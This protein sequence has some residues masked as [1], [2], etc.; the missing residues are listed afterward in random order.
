M[1]ERLSLAV[2]GNGPAAAEAILA[3]RASGYTGSIHLF[4]DNQ[5]PPYNPMLG[6]YLV[7]GTISEDRVFPFGDERTFYRANEVL[8]HLGCPVTR[9]DAEARILVT[10]QGDEY[11]YDR[12]L[13]GT[14]A[15]PAVPPIPGLREV[16]EPGIGWP[17]ES[18]NSEP[19]AFTIQDLAGVQALKQRVD[20]LTARF[21][22]HENKRAVDSAPQTRMAGSRE[23]ASKR[24]RES[25]PRAAVLGA[26]FAG[27]K[28]A[29]VLHQCG[30]RVSLIEREPRLLPLAA[31]P[32]CA[33]LLEEHLAREGYEL[34][35]G[36]ALSRVT[37]ESSAE[38]EHPALRLDFGALPGAAD[39]TGVGGTA[40]EE[41]AAQETVD[42]L[43]VCAGTRPALSFL[44]PGQVAVG[45]GILVDEKMRSSLPTLYAAGDAAQGRN[46]L[47]GRQEIIGLWSSARYQ[48][49]AAGRSLAG[50]PLPYRGG[51]PHNIT[52]VGK[53]LFAAVG[54]IDDYDDMDIIS[55]DGTHEF[56]VWREGRLV[57][58]NLLGR[59]LHAGVIRQALQRAG[60]GAIADREATWISFSG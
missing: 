26:S 50:C 29:G 21:A 42:L 38:N 10:G 60:T 27:V 48:G 43:V 19:L 51:V 34:R 45:T 52:H 39:P 28:I 13:V 12:C 18:H 23:V 32:Q 53:L 35:L 58:V 49:Q 25:S 59:C 37:R 46:L 8:A 4:A 3:L 16:L 44:V 7:A 47:S 2:I 5:H 54:C 15:R 17:G 11:L 30:F 57:G 31:L 1:R 36:A 24:T 40:C 33:R 6:P 14:G 55:K 20:E 41:S 22:Q 56:R 9:L